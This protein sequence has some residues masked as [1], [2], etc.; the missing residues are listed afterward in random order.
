MIYVLIAIFA[1]I[2]CFAEQGQQPRK[3]KKNGKVT[4]S[5]NTNG[6]LNTST[7]AQTDPSRTISR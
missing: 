7:G 5:S 6:Q 3:G 2:L 4:Q 1:I